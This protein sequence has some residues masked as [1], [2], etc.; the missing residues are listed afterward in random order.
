VLQVFLPMPRR[1]DLE[2]GRR[3]SALLRELRGRDEDVGAGNPSLVATELLDRL[4]VEA[5]STTVKPGDA[6]SLTLTDRDWLVAAL[7]MREYGPRIDSHASCASCGETFELSFRLD[8]LM[9]ALLSEAQEAAVEGPDAEGTYALGE[10][11][12]FRLPTPEDERAVA[13]LPGEAAVARLLERCL[14]AA[15]SVDQAAP[16]EEAMSRIG[17][18][19]DLDLAARC[20]ACG[21]EQSARFDVASYFIRALERERPILAREIHSLAAA[22]HWPWTEIV[23]LPRATRRM[24]VDLVEAERERRQ[25][26]WDT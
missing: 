24:H 19:L 22:Y 14:V 15:G 2:L 10:G 4:I 11:I 7:Y 13:A 23:D 16:I 8:E 17:P 21:A 20:A 6:W 3:S 5:P 1:A 26:P 9:T 18:L 12:R 25:R